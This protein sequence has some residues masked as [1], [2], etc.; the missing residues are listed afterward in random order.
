MKSHWDDELANETLLTP[1]N[2]H[3]Y[4][5]I[6]PKKTPQQILR[7]RKLEDSR[8]LQDIEDSREEKTN[9]NRATQVASKESLAWLA[10]LDTTPW[11]LNF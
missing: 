5:Q 10:H 3:I 2:T 11:S 1:V 7:R 8:K 6:I 4:P 9:T